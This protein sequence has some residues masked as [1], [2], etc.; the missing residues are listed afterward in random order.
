MSYAIIEDSGSQ[1]RASVGDE[2]LVDARDAKAGQSITFDKVLLVGGEGAPTIGTPYV[3]GATVQAEVV[4][5]VKGDKI[6]VMRFKRRKGY[7]RKTGHRQN[8]VKVKVTA[9]NG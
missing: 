2:L 4:D 8:Y 9:I 1:I 3:G 5:A 6:H 7:R